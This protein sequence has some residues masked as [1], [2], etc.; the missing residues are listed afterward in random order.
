MKHLAVVC[1]LLVSGSLTAQERSGIEFPFREKDRV[2]WVGSSSTRI[3]VW[4]KTMEFLLATRHTE[5][6]LTFGRF[7]TGGGTFATGVQKMDEWLKPFSPTIVFFN[8]GG[9]DANAG[10]KGLP[11]FRKNIDDAVAKAKSHGATRVILLTPQS[12]DT[13][14]SG[15]EPA[16]RRTL[17]ADTLI[18]VGKDKNW[19]VVDVHRPLENLQAKGQKADEKFTILVDKIH[20]TTPAYIAWG[21]YQYDRLNPPAHESSAS[22]SASGQVTE[23][24]RCRIENVKASDAGLSFTRIDEI[25]P[26]LPPEKLPPR[27]LVPLERLSPYRLKITGLA[28]GEYTIACEGTILGNA[29]GRSLAMGVN[30]NSLLLDSG[31]ETPWTKLATEWWNGKAL[32]QIGRT[33]WTFE[34]RRK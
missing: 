32:D 24:K 4:P 7:T 8:Y 10:E 28:E 31:A 9:N 30:L 26:I 3:G 1:L 17:Y 2:A 13:R 25:I 23:T 27:D 33:R 22:L 6:Q 21:F 12:S 5:L 20:L 34:V 11:Q 29:S 15:V 18:E 14:K 19:P 16:A